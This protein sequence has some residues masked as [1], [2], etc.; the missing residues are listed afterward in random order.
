MT[1]DALFR[2]A[3]VIRADTLGELF[4]VAALLAAP[5]AARRA[6][7]RDPHQRRRPGILA[8]DACEAHGLDAPALSRRRPRP[9]C[10][11]FAAPEAAVANPV[12]LIA[13]A[14]A[15]D[16]ARALRVLTDDP[17][18]DAVVT[19]FVP[20]LVTRADDVARAI[21]DVAAQRT[22]DVPVAAVFMTAEARHAGAPRRRRAG[23]SVPRGRRPGAR[24]RRVVRAAGARRRATRHR[25]PTDSGATRPPP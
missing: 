8:A 20:P 24:A 12:D 5:A 6:V 2:Q 17:A 15:D 3:G 14:S 1:V 16:F 13:G 23:L 11:P 7:G 22:R 21:A 25:H 19:I 10:A 18:V 9:R 4:D